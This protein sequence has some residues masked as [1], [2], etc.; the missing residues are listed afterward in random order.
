MCTM[1]RLTKDLLCYS[2]TG[3][4]PQ[5][6]LFWIGWG[7]TTWNT[8]LLS[9]LWSSLKGHPWC[10]LMK[11]SGIWWWQ[12]AIDV[13]GISKQ[14][15]AHTRTFTFDSLRTL[16]V[17]YIIDLFPVYSSK[18]DWQVAPR[19]VRSLE[20]HYD[21]PDLSGLAS[22]CLNGYMMICKQRFTSHEAG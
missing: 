8:R 18:L 6:S 1:E 14:L 7:H 5:I 19:D 3:T 17:L 15:S 13:V 9:K 12:H 21:T 16:N 2:H 22:S 10:S 11:W 20:G 4:S